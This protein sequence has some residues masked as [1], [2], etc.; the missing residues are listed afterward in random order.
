RALQLARILHAWNLASLT[1]VFISAIA[2]C[3]TVILVRCACVIPAT[4]LSRLFKSERQVRDSSPSWQYV[5]IVGW[6][7]MR[8][9]VSLAAAFA[10]PLALPTGRPFPGRDYI[11]FL[12]FSVILVTL[13]LQ[14]LTLPVLIRKLGVPRDAETD[15]EERLARLEANKEALKWIEEAGA[16]RKFST[17]A[18]NRLQDEYDERIEQLQHVDEQPEDSRCAITTRP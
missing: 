14:G 10:L 18:A 6:A 9:V 15:Q 16:N 17:A 1:G 12:A 2:I 11:L 13:V 3:A 4:Y 5:A 8:G 7:G